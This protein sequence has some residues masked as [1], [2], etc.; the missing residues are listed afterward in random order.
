MSLDRRTFLKRTGGAGAAFIASRLPAPGTASA[1]DMT[2][3]P[4]PAAVHAD[5]VRLL[6]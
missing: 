2:V 6:C 3:R 4:D 1:Q 5:A